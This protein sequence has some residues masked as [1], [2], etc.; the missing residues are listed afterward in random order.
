MDSGDEIDKMLEESFR[1]ME[2]LFAG[3]PEAK[4]AYKEMLKQQF[5]EYAGEEKIENLSLKKQKTTAD[6]NNLCKIT[7][8]QF[9][10]CIPLSDRK[11]LIE[12]SRNYSHEEY[13]RMTYGLSPKSMDEK[14]IMLLE[15]K[16]LRMFRSW[17]PQNCIFEI[18]FEED[19]EVFKIREAWVDQTFLEQPNVY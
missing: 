18:I 15:D 1:R 8:E 3:H 19:G 5:M 16:T 13:R 4:I 12:F 7:R 6:E 10:E 17:T 2:Y 14:W 11:V 9:P